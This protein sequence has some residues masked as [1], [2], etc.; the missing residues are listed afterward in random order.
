MRSKQRQKEN[1]EIIQTL[2]TRVKK[3][4]QEKAATE[5]R[6]LILEQIVRLNVPNA[7]QQSFSVKV[8]AG[9]FAA[10]AG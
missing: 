4:E 3:L 2:T 6:N 8:R 1:E 7:M 5:A 10:R 9:P